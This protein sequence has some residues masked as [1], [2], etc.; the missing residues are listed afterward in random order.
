M[1]SDMGREIR[2]SQILSPRS[3]NAIVIAIDHGL[4][5]GP[6]SGIEDIVAAVG[7]V[8]AGGADAIQLS[9]GSARAARDA[10][11]GRSAPS[12]ILRLDACNFWRTG[13]EIGSHEGYIAPVATPLDA[14]KVGAAAA[15]CF[16]FIGHGDD[17]MEQENLER[18][19]EWAGECQELG[20]PL[21]VEPLPINVKNENDPQLVKLASRIACEASADLI[22][23]NYTG[24]EASFRAVVEA[25]PVPVLL[26][27]GP[28]TSSLREALEMVAGAMRAGARGVVF[29]RNVFQ[30]PDLG[31][32][33]AALGKIIHE[34]GSV[35][36][37]LQLL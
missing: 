12:L 21:M 5:M 14:V 37:A 18:I 19:G 1:Y 33:I 30:A 29:G 32:M 25:C 36:Q 6:I 8:A 9:P 23:T 24:D 31:K 20:I 22:K 3:G 34:H 7:R 15:V 35:D 4:F 2:T 28:R 13:P 27:G 26:R 11:K 17:Q 16:Y 10:F